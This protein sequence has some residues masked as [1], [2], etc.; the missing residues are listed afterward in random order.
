MPFGH[1]WLPM[2]FPQ[3]RS[4]K[5]Q[6]A[7]TVTS[8][9]PSVS[10]NSLLILVVVAA[11]GGVGYLYYSGVQNP[12]AGPATPVRPSPVTPA[13]VVRETLLFF[14]QPGCPP[15]RVMDR[16]MESDPGVKAALARYDVQRVEP[17]SHA[18]LYQQYRVEGTPTFVIVGS[19][20]SE[21]ARVIGAQDAATFTSW[22][23]S[24]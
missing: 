14:T 9:G 23:N 21:V 6:D 12:P 16:L 11:I 17:H 19:D 8:K 24:H 13:P 22:L 2:Y 7:E 10:R 1:Y 15:C 5:K 18:D 4:T 20:K 3:P